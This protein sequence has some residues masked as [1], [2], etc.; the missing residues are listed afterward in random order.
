MT[1][2]LGGTKFLQEAGS[3]VI[4]AQNNADVTEQSEVEML[5]REGDPHCP[6][7]N[8]IGEIFSKL[9]SSMFARVTSTLIL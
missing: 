9:P 2:S 3:S 5:E 6:N 8:M 7:G 1:V 4:Y